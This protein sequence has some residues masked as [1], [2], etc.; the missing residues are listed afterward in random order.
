M[1]H[2]H[3]QS[4]HH[5]FRPHPGRHHTPSHHRPIRQVNCVGNVIIV[6]TR[7][8]NL[9]I[10]DYIVVVRFGYLVISKSSKF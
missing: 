6:V 7:A 4:I 1:R 2:H 8:G 9:V 3:R 10:T 5:L